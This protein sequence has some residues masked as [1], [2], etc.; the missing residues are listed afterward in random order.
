M[1]SRPGDGRYPAMMP[2]VMKIPEPT[3]EPM[4]RKVASRRFIFR[5]RRGWD[6]GLFMAESGFLVLED[7]GQALRRDGLQSAAGF[8]PD[9]PGLK[10]RMDDGA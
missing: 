10:K 1:R 5:S 6:S 4:T 9:R 2:E 8:S 7:P 3:T